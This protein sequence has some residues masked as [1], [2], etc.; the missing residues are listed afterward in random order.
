MTNP[1]IGLGCMRLSTEPDRDE[2]RSLAVLH[3]AF[4]AGVTFFDTADAYCWD[5]SERGHNERLIATAL[6]TWPGDRS[7]IRVATKGGLT[8]PGGRWEA[9]GRARHLAASCEA[10]RRALGVDTIHLYQLHAPDPQTPLATSVRALAALKRD[11]LIDGIGLSNVTVGQIEE[12][13]AIAPIDSIQVELSV[14]HDEHILSGVVE[15]CVE[16]RLPL[17]AY[18]PLGGPA[19]R[20]RTMADPALVEVAERHRATPAEIALAWLLNVSDLVVPLPGATTV[21]TVRSIARAAA[22]T[23]TGDDRALLE[24]RFPS[25]RSPRQPRLGVQAAPSRADGEV[26]LVMGLPGAGKSRL[27]QGLTAQG[28]HRLNRDIAGGT[29]K[30]L[31]PALD[32][33]LAS[34]VSRI[35]LDNTYVSRKSRAEVLRAASA[36][37]FPV[38]CI[39]LSTPVEE[40]QTNAVSRI[41]SRYG[42][43]P[44]EAA[45]RKLARRDPAAFLPA[46]QFRYQRELEPPHPS[47]GFSCIDVVPFERQTDSSSTGRAVIV[48]CDGLLLRSKSG[49]RSPFAPDDVEVVAER[50]AILRQYRED[51]WR[52]L[53]LSWQPGIAE[54][55]HTSEGVRA[56]FA[57]MNELLEETPP[58]RSGGPGLDID[59]EFCPH[60]AGPPRCWCRK[61]L[62]GLGVLFAHRYRLD[63]GRCIYVG[64]GP[65]DPGFAR[66]LGFEYR[67]AADFF[68]SGTASLGT[69]P[70]A[71]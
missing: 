56:I 61:P 65:Q 51:G 68:D 47:E 57:R 14:W 53:G 45:L 40:A 4:D 22:V 41:V 28:Y 23:L 16:H 54:G 29:L 55:T 70:A 39:W 62:P 11:G 25:A 35:V 58:R 24:Q 33:A 43:L 71:G 60:A 10:S 9:D 13:R 32:A 17:L 31:L 2:A 42:F 36:R 5:D 26:V 37:G 50:G 7:R 59:V 46:V 38:R 69:S 18:R 48:W 44:D 21:E 27:A 8:R 63:P 30:D 34:G 49:R 19:R 6:A 66:R 15:Y 52:V 64:A 1:R 12:A 20:Y 67:D 3:A